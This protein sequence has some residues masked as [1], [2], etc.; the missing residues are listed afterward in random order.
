MLPLGATCI[1]MTRACHLSHRLI[2]NKYEATCAI[3]YMILVSVN[4]YELT[5]GIIYITIS[6]KKSHVNTYRGL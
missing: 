1:F 6:I 3:I 5:Y 4:K 2:L